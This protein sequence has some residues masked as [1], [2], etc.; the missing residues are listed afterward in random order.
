[1]RFDTPATTNP[2]DQLKVVG[3]PTDRIDGPLKTTG[4]APYAYERHDAVPNPAYGYVVGAAIAKGR[5]ASH[6][7]VRGAK[8]APG[9]LADRHRGQCRQARQGRATTPRNCSAAPRSSTITRR[10]PWWSPR[11]SS[12]RAPPRSWCG[13][14]MS[15][16]TGAFDLAAGKDAAA[17]PTERLRR[18]AGYR[19]RRLRRRI[20]RRA[21]QARRDLH[22]ARPGPRDDGAARVDRA[23]GSGD[24]LTLWT[25]NQMVD[26]GA[27]DVAKTLGIPKEKVRLVSPF[28]G[29]G[30]GGKLFVRA[31]ALLA[32]LG[33]RAAGRPVKVALHAAA[34]VQQHDAP[35]GDDPAHPHRRRRA[36]ARSPPS[37]HESWSGDLP[38]GKPE[39]AVQP[40]A[41]A[42]CRR[43]PHDG[44][45]AGRARPARGQCHA[46]A[47]RGAG[48]DGAGDRHGRD[49]REARP[50]SGRV[51]HPQRHPGR[52]REA[53]AAV[54]AAPAGRVPAHRRRALRLEQ[55]QRRSPA[56]CATGAGWSA[57]AWPRRSATT[58]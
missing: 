6:R 33:A 53:R 57:W 49:G 13:S 31:D 10:S 48:H 2:I 17:K 45:A 28:I 19:R 4:T 24:K 12:R 5:I 27:G 44:D 30:F 16:P 55:A 38:G 21:G 8:A 47:R 29:G 7:S 20:R 11:P 51:P 18:P 9:V 39:T 37:R 26:W 54:L 1:M 58:C 36:T 23:P 40:D 3:Q 15:A 52:S 35:A 25:S 34:D 42:L 41:P 32:A 22:H 43:Q 56:R 46:R 14:T 50:G